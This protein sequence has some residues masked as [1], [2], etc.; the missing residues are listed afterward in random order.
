MSRPDD[1]A[2]TIGELGRDMCRRLSTWLCEERGQ[3]MGES[4]AALW[5]AAEV[6]FDGRRRNGCRC[7]RRLAS[8]HIELLN[9]GGRLS[10]RPALAP[11]RRRI[12]RV[13]SYVGVQQEIASSIILIDDNQGTPRRPRWISPHYSSSFSLFSCLAAA[14][15][16]AVA[17]I[18]PFATGRALTSWIDWVFLKRS[19]AGGSQRYGLVNPPNCGHAHSQ[20]Q[21]CL[22]DARRYAF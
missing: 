20:L 9:S 16:V 10:G 12:W 11:E 3:N 19:P 18:E 22:S 17:G 4:D 7:Q 14:G 5:I 2:I 15:T 1:S 21:S 6:A 8:R 13:T